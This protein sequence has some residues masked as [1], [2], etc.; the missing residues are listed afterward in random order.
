[1][2]KH[3]IIENH[4]QEIPCSVSK[5]KA[6]CSASCTEQQTG[7][8]DR[9]SQDHEEPGQEQAASF[10]LNLTVPSATQLFKFTCAFNRIIYDLLKEAEGQEKIDSNLEPVLGSSLL[11]PDFHFLKSAI[12]SSCNFLVE[13]NNFDF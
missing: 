10:Q 9:N 6:I 13:G 12:C 1:M 4:L 7:S 3:L 11:I 8:P 2:S 5:V